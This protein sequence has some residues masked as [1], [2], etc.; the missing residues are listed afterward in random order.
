MGSPERDYLKTKVATSC[1]IRRAASWLVLQQFVDK[2][3]PASYMH[4]SAEIGA[5][6]EVAWRRL[7]H[8]QL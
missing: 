3:R 6:G 4:A 8:A 2:V 7:H 5:L 1:Q